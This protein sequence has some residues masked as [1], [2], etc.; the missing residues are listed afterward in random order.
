MKRKTQ[1]DPDFEVTNKMRQ[2][3]A[4]RGMPNPDSEIEHFIDYHLAH[5]STMRD[6]QAAFRTWLRNAK[7][8]NPKNNKPTGDTTWANS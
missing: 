8:W 4:S 1:I 5:G 7:K 3:A 6:W 2:W